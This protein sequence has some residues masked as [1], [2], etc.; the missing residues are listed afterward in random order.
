MLRPQFWARFY[1]KVTLQWATLKF[2]KSDWRSK[3]VGFSSSGVRVVWTVSMIT[4]VCMCVSMCASHAILQQKRTW[5][6]IMISR[7]IQIYLSTLVTALQSYWVLAKILRLAFK[8]A[9]Q[10]IFVTLP[11]AEAL[12]PHGL[13]GRVLWR[14]K[15]V[16]WWMLAIN[17]V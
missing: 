2:Y 6:M 7:F 1:S 16:P 12:A 17:L 11:A 5:S 4:N 10:T 9:R 13:A 14:R 8:G 3:R 15:R